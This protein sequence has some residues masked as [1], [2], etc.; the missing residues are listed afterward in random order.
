MGTD[1]L[2]AM[3]VRLRAEERVQLP[4]LPTVML[5]SIL[6]MAVRD[7]TCVRSDRRVCEG[8]PDGDTCAYRALFEPPA[9]GAVEHGVTDAAPPPFV[10]S[11]EAPVLG[12][13]P[14]RLEKGDRADFRL[15]LFGPA[16]EHGSLIVAALRAG[17]A[18]GVGR[19]RAMMVVEGVRPI[20]ITLAAAGRAAELELRTPL[21]LTAQ[22]KVRSRFTAEDLLE[23]L[24]RRLATL[25]ALYGIGGGPPTP[26]SGE[27]E[28]EALD[29]RVVR[30]SRWSS[31]QRSRMDLPGLVGTLEL[32]GDL[33]GV[34]PLLALGEWVQLDK[35][36]SMGFG[37]YRLRGIGSGS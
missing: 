20:E 5:R 12:E 15:V 22:G 36:T 34:W 13:G 7:L 18:R 29:T 21:R 31:R 23:G 14:A 27:L 37:R 24:G 19:E 9:R 16:C 11:P 35:G 26:R 28:L 1:G 32:R 2:R 3:R 8:C 25:S 6:G 33:Q 30:V 10:L 17:L 4:C